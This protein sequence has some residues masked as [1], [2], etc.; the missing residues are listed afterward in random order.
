MV[1]QLFGTLG[2]VEWIRPLLLTTPFESWHGLLAEHPFREPLT[3]GL[4]VSAAW[5]VICLGAAFLTLRRRDIT[6]G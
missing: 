6:E 5:C 3:T 2:G 4:L 1:M